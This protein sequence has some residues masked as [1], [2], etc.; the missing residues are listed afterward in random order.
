MKIYVFILG[1]LLTATCFAE[2]RVRVYTDYSPVRILYLLEGTDFK[3][4]ADKA[5]LSGNFKDVDSSSI[6]K[7]RSD[8]NFWKFESGQIKVD[9][10]K[11]KVAQDLKAKKDSDKDSAIGKLKVLG[12]TDEELAVLKIG[13]K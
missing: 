11:K 7:D 3:L 13:E 5:G 8:R 10:V 12:L 9:N 2:E 1:L 4:E 6:P